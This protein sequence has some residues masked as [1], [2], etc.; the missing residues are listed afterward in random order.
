MATD[1]LYV[2]VARDCETEDRAASEWH[3]DGLGENE[4][5]AYAECAEFIAWACSPACD[6]RQGQGPAHEYAIAEVDEQGRVIPGATHRSGERRDDEPETAERTAR[7]DPKVGQA[8]SLV[9]GHADRALAA[10]LAYVYASDADDATCKR[11]AEAL[12]T[13]YTVA[14]EGADDARRIQIALGLRIIA[15]RL[16]IPAPRLILGRARPPH[17]AWQAA[18]DVAPDDV[19]RASDDEG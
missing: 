3:D 10:L 15:H 11:V 5:R 8:L 2:V 17:A 12:A 14:S 1:T 13:A 19:R 9:S 16:G 18:L 7:Q 4:P 6:W